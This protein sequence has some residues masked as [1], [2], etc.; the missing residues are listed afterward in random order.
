ME[1]GVRFELTN[2]DFA[3]RALW[4]LG[5]PDIYKTGYAFF[6]IEPNIA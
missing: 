6:G 5:Y 1:S 4:P 2:N 3:D